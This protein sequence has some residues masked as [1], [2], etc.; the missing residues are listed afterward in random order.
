MH[1]LIVFPIHVQIVV[2]PIPPVFLNAQAM[3]PTVILCIVRNV[4]PAFLKLIICQSRNGL[5]GIRCRN[6]DLIFFI[7]SRIDTPAS[8]CIVQIVTVC[9]IVR[10]CF[11]VRYIHIPKRIIH[12]A[13]DVQNQ[14]D[15]DRNCFL[16]DLERI[17]NICFHGKIVFPIRTLGNAL[18]DMNRVVSRLVLDRLLRIPSHLHSAAGD[19]AGRAAVQGQVPLGSQRY[20]R[21]QADGQ[22][23]RQQ[24]GYDSFR[25]FFFSPSCMVQFFCFFTFGFFLC[26]TAGGP[27]FRGAMPSPMRGRWLGGTPS[28]MRWGQMR[29]RD[30]VHLISHLR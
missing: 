26:A 1:F 30:A 28:R 7:F 14:H 5:V 27:G 22:D 12:G 16:L 19:R 6:V 17:G 2:P 10:I 21:E 9:H 11:K 18:F 13:G 4:I 15:I 29:L 8:L 20:R 24:Q 25:H 23:Q 3:I